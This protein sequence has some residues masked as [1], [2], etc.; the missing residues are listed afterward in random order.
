MSTMQRLLMGLA[1]AVACSSL[2]AAPLTVETLLTEADTDTFAGVRPAPDGR[3]VAFDISRSTESLEYE[4]PSQTFTDTGYPMWAGLAIFRG[5]IL[6]LDTGNITVL[7]D[8]NGVSWGG[9]WSPDGERYAFYSN[10]SGMATVWIWDRRS[11][12]TRQL[13]DAVVR[14]FR[15]DDAPLWTPDGRRVIFKA[16][17]EGK[18]LKDMQRYNEEYVAAF[19]KNAKTGASPRV[20]VYRAPDDHSTRDSGGSLAFRNY[21]YE[22]DLV[23]VDVEGGSLVRIARSVHP[24]RFSL[25]PDGRS[26]GNLN[27]DGIVPN[28]QRARFSLRMYAMDSHAEKILDPNISPGDPAR[29][30]WSSQSDRVAYSTHEGANLNEWGAFVVNVRT[31]KRTRLAPPTGRSFATLGWGAPVWSRDGAT[32]YLLDVPFAGEGAGRPGHLWAVGADGRN[33]REI[34]AIP[35]RRIQD[36]VTTPDQNSYWSADDG[37]SMVVRTDA[38]DTKQ[39]GFYRIDLRSGSAQPIVEVDGRIQRPLTASLADRKTIPFFMTDVAHAPEVH[40][41]DV[42]QAS[43]RRVTRL[44]PELLDTPMGASRLIDWLS[45]TGERLKGSVLM[46][47]DAKPGQPLPLVVWVYGGDRGADSLNSFGFGWGS[48]FNMQM[49]ATRGYAVFYPDVP[50]HDGRPVRDVGDA[51]LSGVN[52]LVELGIADPD[53]LGI[54][55]QSFGGYNTMSLLTQTTRF[56]AAVITGSATTNTFEGYSRFESGVDVGTGY[57]EQGQGALRATPWEKPLRYL[58]NSP[59]FFL[60]RVETPVMIIRGSSDSISAASGSTFNSLRRLGK[61]A[62]YIEYENEGHVI[63]QSANLVDIWNRRLAWLDRFL[64][65]QPTQQ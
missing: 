10:A 51:V 54:M 33:A 4:Y 22:S 41:L 64:R 48:T 56:K 62:E 3:S 49:L 30:S 29:F 6:D 60:D 36:I 21:R 11:G 1:C 25:S 52:R 47:P 9:S 5:R 50:I 15:N 16:V 26:L 37:A 53:R 38:L 57:Y 17:P 42:G 13:S 40:V 34:G 14:M 58:E 7:P 27:F 59:W 2:Q 46:P 45:P 31:G 32:V 55:G 8:R 43:I 19:E 44:H 23:A 12:K 63:Q 28:T 20:H 65:P 61:T 24:L 35:G 39:N 18:T